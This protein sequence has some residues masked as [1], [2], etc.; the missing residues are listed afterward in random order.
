MMVGKKRKFPTEF[1]GFLIGEPALLGGLFLMPWND[2]DEFENSI[3]HI[4]CKLLKILVL[5]GFSL[6]LSPPIR[7]LNLP[8][9]TLNYGGF[10]CPQ[11]PIF[12]INLP[13]KSTP[14][15]VVR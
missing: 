1:S 7:I 5:F 12:P 6:A 15:S 11:L 13:P 2:V 3:R 10:P 14:R 4:F 9:N 8:P